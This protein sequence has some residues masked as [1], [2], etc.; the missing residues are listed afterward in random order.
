MAGTQSIVGLQSGIDTTSLVDSLIAIG[1][2]NAVLLEA[3]KAEK[4]N[5]ISALKALEAKVLGLKS[6]VGGLIRSANWEQ[7]TVSVSDRNIVGTAT[8]GMVSSGQYDLQVLSLARN[9]QV[10][11]QG[12]DS[13]TDSVFGTGSLQ[14][15]VGDGSAITID[16][17]DTN[18]SLVGIRDAINASSAGVSASIIGDGSESKSYRLVLSGDLT[19]RENTI[20]VTSSL[21]DGENLDYVNSSFDD[22]E[23][24]SVSSSSS[25][26]M[27]LGATAAYTGTE[28]KT[29]T[30]TVQGSGSQTVGT[31]TITL[32]WTDGTNSGSIDITA[33]D[34]EVELTGTGADGL[35]VQFGAGTLNAGDVF[36]I[37]TFTPV[38]QEASDARITLG[39]SGGGGS[40]INI[41]STTNSI[42]DVIGGLTLNLKKETEAGESISITTAA[43]TGA[44]KERIETF[45]DTYN[46]VIDYID[47]QNSYDEDTGFS[48]ILFNDTNVWLMQQQLRSA[49]G[50]AVQGIEGQY[51]NLYSIGIRTDNGEMRIVD[52]SRLNE[53]IA[54][55][56]EGVMRLFQAGGDSTNS[57]IDFVS[58]T[59]D[60]RDGYGYQVNVTQA[61]EQG[62]MVGTSITDP[63]TTP[64]SIDA[65]ND[66]F[67]LIVDGVT[68]GTISLTKTTYSSTTALI[69]ELQTQI[70]A[71]GIIAGKGISVEW[72]DNG[73]GTGYVKM[74]NGAYGD[75]SEINIDSSFTS[76]TAYSIL[77]LT[78][79]TAT[80]GKDVQGS[81]NGEAAEGN[82][83]FLT[84][85]EGNEYTDGL[86]LQINLEA[87]HLDETMGEGFITPTR[88]MADQLNNFLESL[89]AA[90]DGVF[91]RQVVSYEKQIEVLDDR[92]EDIDARLAIRRQ[93]L[94]DQ[95]Y[96]MEVALGELDAERQFLETQLD[97]INA[98][99]KFSS[100][101]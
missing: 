51:N 52:E 62:T 97:G 24:Y 22:P 79:A 82:G 25:S 23:N 26:S 77:G 39:T 12:F 81:I 34:T 42:R 64:I 95:F 93:T 21:I 4:T 29:Y 47:E 94:L 67:R 14:I 85:L 89:T 13:Q 84:G 43:D 70:D 88:G 75:N 32:N 57:L 60:T 58:M 92:I 11:S 54:N 72:V 20:N 76:N 8:T 86:K 9:H 99:W 87:S 59:S 78:S 33:A 36:E 30:F 38:L 66:D 73:D 46:G 96:E 15:S 40:P 80:A 19:G 49:T 31:D 98:N 90:V 6:S 101:K 16:V 41:T 2:G 68:S 18:N 27:S 83:R 7:A 61:A 45:I 56:M 35:K 1:R 74:T 10:A 69:N 17:D 37:S 100:K 91:A 44:I 3:Q 71:D 53:A 55:D 65:S 63:A 5:I 28:N 48:G 50:R